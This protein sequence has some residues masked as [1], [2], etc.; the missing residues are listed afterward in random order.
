MKKL[1][2]WFVGL[3]LGVVFVAVVLLGV[4]IFFQIP[5]D[6]TRF[7]EHIETAASS[8]FHRPVRIEDSIVISTSLKPSIMIKGLTIENPLGF[9]TPEFLS[10]D[11]AKIQ[12]ELL[13]LLA[14]KIHFS[15]ITI[16]GVTMTLEETADGR[17]NWISNPNIQKAA[18]QALEVEKAAEPLE[19]GGSGQLANDTLVV[20]SLDVQDV[21][22]KFHRP[23][24]EG[25]APFHL[26]HCSGAMVTGRPLHL[27]IDGEI[28]DTPYRVD[29]S[30]GSLEELLTENATW[31]EMRAAVAETVFMVKGHVDLATSIKSLK[32]HATAEGD[33]LAS[34][35]TLFNLDLPPFRQYRLETDLHL[36]PRHFEL[37]RLL[38]NTGSSSL[39]GSGAIVVDED[40]LSIELQL[41]SPLLQIDD[42]VFDD[43]SWERNV[44]E[45]SGK[46]V[47]EGI[48]DESKDMGAEDA[49]D[50]KVERKLLDPE[51]LAKFDGSFSLDGG[52]VLSGEDLLG[53][54]QVT[55]TVKDG[56]ITISPLSLRL[57]GGDL[58]MSASL[59]PGNRRSDA[60]LKIAM[61]NFDIGILVRRAKP[62]SVMG[63]HVN[64]DV[65]IQSS[66]AAVSELLANGNGYFDFS[67]NLENFSS[68]IIDLWAV[69][70]V[71]AIV[72]NAEKD[73]SRLN[74]AVGRWSVVDGMLQADAFFMDT[75]RIRI[76]AGGTVDLKEQR[77]D[78]KVRPQ[79]KKAQFFSLAT[80]L[81]VHGS[82]GDLNIGPGSGGIIGTAVRFIASP[83]SVPLS[84][85]FSKEIP[86]D[87]KDVCSMMIGPA[88]RQNIDIP[89]CN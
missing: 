22:I 39:E 17:V 54:G 49:E 5:I 42:V 57:P 10:V 6:L 37:E 32:V 19:T 34:L 59:K 89:L 67:G 69:N 53:S 23:G 7:R 35:N 55:A 60:E 74:C 13:P 87:G 9:A 4:V 16:Q 25:P 68:G 29:V 26:G 56:R 63:G 11:R 58:A 1:L 38:V 36:Q 76:C 77:I 48:E 64:L 78:L 8:T 41:R 65:D 43:W 52:K 70:L 33:N 72:A 75:S 50:T 73:K 88:D 20:R 62:Q 83:V 27:I 28:Y 46:P 40:K 45:G 82:F 51:L 18:K 44:A 15:Q 71:A 21:S 24:Q 79:P 47:A 12:I 85:T 3:L 84:R 61:K 66:A 31:M 81:Q 14:A 2:G 80:P 30:V 86:S